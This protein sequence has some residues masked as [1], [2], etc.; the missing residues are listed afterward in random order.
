MPT[1]L[2]RRVFLSVLGASAL[3]GG[4]LRAGRTAVSAQTNSAAAE[5]RVLDLLRTF[6]AQGHHR[7]GTDVDRTSGEWLQQEAAKAGGQARL[8]A[9]SL[10]RLDVDE[11]YVEVA[12]RRIP[13]LPFFDGGLTSSA[14]TAAP[15]GP[16]GLHLARAD[17]TAVGT[18][19]GFLEDLRRA[20][21]V[22]A[23]V[24]TTET[25][26][27]GLV[28]SN[29]R[30]FH[31]PFGCPVL[32]VSGAARGLLEQAAAS[33]A[34]ATVVCRA[35]RT[36]TTATNVIVD[37]PG[38]MAEAA[39]LVVITPR[40]GWWTC[41]AERGGGL[42]CWLEAIRR[43]SARRPGGRR[44]LFVASS[45]HELGHLG[46]EAF[47][48]EQPALL[49][50]AH[51]WIH[52]GA[53]IGAG[54]AGAAEAGVRVQASHDDLDSLMSGA[55]A[56][57]NAPVVGR[58]PRGRVPSGEARNL[59]VGNAR[60]VSLLGSHNPWFHHEDDRWPASV[61]ADLVA[62]YAAG[63]SQAVVELARL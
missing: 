13:G 4:R 3:A 61:T 40:S 12:G 44:A 63:V 6:D 62:K 28:P 21:S 56:A 34:T 58:L 19:G 27:P 18:E 49:R 32:Q 35:T 26:V 24:V 36:R 50:A 47:L 51:A 7:T 45:G 17:R 43:L 29:A 55:L 54:A 20:G 30:A 23:I 15:F 59:H 10:D 37:V 46:L 57:A 2:P 8:M 11:A 25:G 5:T 31:E 52:L 16:G 42:I 1:H 33:G 48:H 39:P 14:G 38:S 41:T 9:F 60:Y 53:N 22:R